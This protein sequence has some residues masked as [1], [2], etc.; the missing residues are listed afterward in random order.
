MTIHRNALA[1]L[2]AALISLFFSANLYAGTVSVPIDLSANVIESILPGGTVF[3]DSK[4]LFGTT[5]DPVQSAEL[6]HVSDTGVNASGRSTNI[7]GAFASSLASS[8]GNGGVGVSQLVFGSPGD[9]GQDAVRQLV[10]QSLW[11][12]TFLYDGPPAH[13]IL[14]LNIPTLQV[15]LLGVPPRRTGTSATETAEAV[16]RVDSVITH[17]DGSMAQGVFQYG[18][19][20]F[21]RQVPSGKDLLN[22]ADKEIIEQP[23]PLVFTPTLT[24]NGDDFNPSYTLSPVFL[25]LD[26]GV[27]QPGDIESWVYTLTA[28]GTTHGFERG[29]FAF[30]GDPFGAEVVTGNL[31]ETI[32]ASTDAPEANT[33]ALMLLGLAGLLLRRWRNALRCNSVSGL[34]R[35]G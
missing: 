7:P 1:A 6:L 22:L 23:N 16:A 25:D 14:H 8:D 11:T 30:L 15:G 32:T 33:S 4:R 24:F 19:R 13:V 27:I 29:Y 21:E 2:I 17:S 35:R 26:L 34:L 5:I 12:H 28:E 31:V 18:L 10:A 3:H 20:E 9:P